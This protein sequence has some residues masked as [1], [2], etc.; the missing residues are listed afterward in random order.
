VAVPNVL[1]PRNGFSSA[2][3]AWVSVLRRPWAHLRLRGPRPYLLAPR[4]R[5]RTAEAIPALTGL[6]WMAD[7]GQA[8][9][10]AEAT[11]LSAEPFSWTA[12]Q[13][14]PHNSRTRIPP[15]TSRSLPPR[16]I[17][18]ARVGPRDAEKS[19]PA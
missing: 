15:A 16:R 7:G 11:P 19:S 17:R 9:S 13:A 3:T 18:W 12:H 2:R 6:L 8:T 14:C 10:P 1:C 4:Y 5:T